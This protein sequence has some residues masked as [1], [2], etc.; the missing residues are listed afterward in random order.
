M[1]TV[2]KTKLA[3]A[4]RVKKIYIFV[5]VGVPV[6]LIV[7]VFWFAHWVFVEFEH[8][9]DHNG[10]GWSAFS[11]SLRKHVEGGP[12]TISDF[13]H[14]EGSVNFT[15]TDEQKNSYHIWTSR[16]AYSD[17]R[18]M[19][20]LQRAGLRLTKIGSVSLVCQN[21]FGEEIQV[22]V[23][24]QDLGLSVQ[25]PE[26]LNAMLEMSGQ[27]ILPFAESLPQTYSISEGKV[28]D[29]PK[30]LSV[31]VERNSNC[32]SQTQLLMEPATS[33]SCQLG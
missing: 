27:V 3:K 31:N 6:F 20:S 25:K 2:S 1:F 33:V 9:E 22:F 17:A 29:L 4:S 32:C 19:N 10:V 14:Y 23:T 28:V 7:G 13:G 24:R 30:G 12:Y 15:V 8:R 5:L 18:D 16:S 26:S 21:N 11:Q